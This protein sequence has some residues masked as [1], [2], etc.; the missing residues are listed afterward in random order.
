MTTEKRV[1][2]ACG[3]EY[4][5]TCLWCPHCLPDQEPFDGLTPDERAVLDFVSEGLRTGKKV[6]GPLNVASDQR[7]FLYEAEQELRDSIVYM[8]GQIQ[9]LRKMREQLGEIVI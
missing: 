2:T 3:G 9:R 8:A 6:Y 1:C 5:T 4:L 7:D